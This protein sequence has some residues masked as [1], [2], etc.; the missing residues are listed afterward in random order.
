MPKS[1]E[2][3]PTRVDA[4]ECPGLWPWVGLWLTLDIA[5]HAYCWMLLWYVFQGAYE[6]EQEV[7]AWQGRHLPDGGFTELFFPAYVCLVFTW[8]VAT[9][10]A[11]L[12]AL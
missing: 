6:W 7:A 9:H 3:W 11:W 4:R 2:S 12:A 1:L 5:L 10:S 8:L